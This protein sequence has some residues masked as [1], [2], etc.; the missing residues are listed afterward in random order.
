MEPMEQAS[1]QQKIKGTFSYRLVDI[2]TG[3]II[4]EF[5][6]PNKIMDTVPKMFFEIV[7]GLDNT[8]TSTR[9]LPKPPVNTTLKAKDFE[10]C[11]V[12]IG[13]MGADSKGV[14]KPITGKEHTL[15]ALDAKGGKYPGFAYQA[16]WEALL[17]EETNGI[18]LKLQ[19]EGPSNGKFNGPPLQ[20]SS[21]AHSESGLDIQTEVKDGIITFRIDMLELTGN[22]QKFSEAALFVRNKQDPFFTKAG[23]LGTKS[24]G[25][26]FAKKN[27]KPVDKTRSCVLQLEWKLDFNL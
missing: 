14:P 27:F 6:E 17:A 16:T 7:S 10:L 23:T 4:Q 11:A 19:T 3:K 24:L 2:K 5:K 12:A 25:T 8:Y 20:T 1:I 22:G 13:T 15:D 18:G 9:P 26:I 21:S